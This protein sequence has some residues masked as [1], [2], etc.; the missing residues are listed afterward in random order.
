MILCDVCHIGRVHLVAAAFMFPFGERML[1]Y[2]QAPAEICDVCGH[3]RYDPL[4]VGLIE[5]LIYGQLQDD[6]DGMR[7]QPMFLASQGWGSRRF[8]AI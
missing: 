2:P 5:S 3:T 8:R 4:F 7:R 1:L 6:T